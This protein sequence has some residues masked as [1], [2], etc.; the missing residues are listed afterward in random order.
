[1]THSEA[2]PDTGA[3]MS[4]EALE[5]IDHDGL[6]AYGRLQY[7][8]PISKSHNDRNEIIE[9]ILEAARKFKG[10]AGMTQVSTD[11]TRTLGMG[12]VKVRVSPGPHNPNNRPVIVGMNFEMASIPV[13]IDTIM[14]EKWLPCLSDAVRTNYRVGKDPL[15]G[16]D[17]LE[18]TDEHQYPFSVLD[19]GPRRPSPEEIAA[20]Q[21][22]I[23][24]ERAR[25]EEL[26][27]L[28]DE[29]ALVKQAKAEFEAEEEAAVAKAKPKAKAKKED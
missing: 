18:Y 16:E 6:L 7:A 27:A 13:N 12:Q 3:V 21:A 28:K 8:L 14:D 29:L 1:M 25:Q 10:N 9:M 24:E 2:L 22:K 19:R 4:R 15:T 20:K 26:Q 11:D 23:A 17:T 5:A